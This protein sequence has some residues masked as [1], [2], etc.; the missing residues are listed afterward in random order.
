[1]D[2]E[3]YRTKE[4]VVSWREKDP[5]TRHRKYLTAS[6]IVDEKDIKKIEDSVNKSMEKAK[7][8]ALNSPYPDRSEATSDI[9]ATLQQGVSL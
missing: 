6:G 4:E 5:I 8:F 7:D 3:R 1:M 2:A 9:Y